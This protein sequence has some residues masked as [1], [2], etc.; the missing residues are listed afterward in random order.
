MN[1]REKFFN[2]YQLNKEIIAGLKQTE[3]GR[4]FVRDNPG[5]IEA[6]TATEYYRDI[7]KGNTT[8]DTFSRLNIKTVTEASDPDDEPNFNTAF[9][10]SN[11][12]EFPTSWAES[13]VPFDISGCKNIGVCS[14]IH[15]PYHDE[16]VS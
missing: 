1:A 8:E 13:Y 14:D 5:V 6:K 2:W 3:V 15:I 9:F 12:I 7:L 16:M 11:M 4:L 10:E